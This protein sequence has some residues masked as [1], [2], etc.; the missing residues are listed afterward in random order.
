MDAS[1]FQF[2][3]MDQLLGDPKK[4]EREQQEFKKYLDRLVTEKCLPGESDVECEFDILGIDEN[5]QI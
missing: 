4:F 2:Q 5:S 3:Q 1:N